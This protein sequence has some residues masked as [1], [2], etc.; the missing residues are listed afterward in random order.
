MRVALGPSGWARARV[1]SFAVERG[2][3]AMSEILAVVVYRTRP[4]RVE[5]AIHVFRRV[6]EPTHAENGAVT[7]ALTQSN[8]DPSVFVLVER[9]A[10][11]EAIDEH[12]N[13]PYA[14]NFATEAQGLLSAD[15]EVYFLTDV[16]IGDP[17]KGKL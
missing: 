4:D 3:S 14:A 13:Q 6:M 1:H 8:E 10:S 7:C 15:P 2:R 17:V 12:L 5:D 9:W 11:Q 16:P